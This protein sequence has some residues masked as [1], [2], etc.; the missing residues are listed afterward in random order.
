MTSKANIDWITKTCPIN[1][2]INWMEGHH[3]KPHNLHKFPFRHS[4]W[5]RIHTAVKHRPMWKKR[6]HITLFSYTIR[7]MSRVY[8]VCTLFR[9]E[10]CRLKLNQYWVSTLDACAI[11]SHWKCKLNEFAICIC[12][13]WETC[14]QFF[15]HSFERYVRVKIFVTRNVIIPWQRKNV[16]AF[17]LI[18]TNSAS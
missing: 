2:S 14:A 12:K 3:T 8:A 5:F 9:G 17:T 15:P 16:L 7:W 18:R 11:S 6:N 13:P 1:W 10:W 4:S